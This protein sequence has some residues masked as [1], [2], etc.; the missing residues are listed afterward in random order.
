MNDS[1]CQ[2][3][4]DSIAVRPDGTS[5]PCCKFKPKKYHLWPVENPMGPDMRNQP[6]WLN[7]RQ[8]MLAGES[9]EEC[10]SC[11]T[12]EASGAKSL[13]TIRREQYPATY[14]SSGAAPLKFLE[15]SFSNLCNLA[16]VSCTRSFSS[17][18]AT[19]DFK[20]GRNTSGSFVEH[21][22]PIEELEDLSHI[23]ELK[24]IGGEPF[25]EQKRFI[26]LMKKI[27]FDNIESMYIATNG[28]RLPNDELSGLIEKC[29]LV[30]LKV[31]LDGIGSVN[32]WYRWPSKFDQ[33]ESIMQQYQELW[34]TH[35]NI[36][37]ETH[38]VMNIFNIYDL[39]NIIEYM[40]NKFPS[41][42]MSFNWI[43]WPVWQ[44]VSLLPADEKL[45][46]TEQFLEYADTVPGNWH[47]SLGNPFKIA[48]DRMN[49]QAYSTLE[50]LKTQ[51]ILLAA[52]RD[53][54]VHSMVPA[55]SHLLQQDTLRTVT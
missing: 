38:T 1:M 9:V 18:W 52:E 45:Q 26:N 5:I 41:W 12:E 54:D 34:G 33:V 31:S 22:H 25:M 4:W 39:K 35:P 53:L 29:K 10:A 55:I 8:K 48:V 2:W 51:T 24:I 44:T 50:E 46:L 19:E 14:T 49:D 15:M 13:R 16:C 37:L 17:T 3:A 30:R 43:S 36:S 20:H 40:T 21:G 28:T 47:T 23:T 32:D 42:K 11:F 27:N 6:G 7:V